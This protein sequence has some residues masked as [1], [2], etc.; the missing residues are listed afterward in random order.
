MKKVS[1]FTIAATFA[2][3]FLGAGYVS[4]QEMKQFFGDYGQNWIWGLLVSV[5]FQTLLGVVILLVSRKTGAVSM[6]R[7]VVSKNIPWLRNLMG[8]LI[9]LM[10]FAIN[11]TM[12]AA[13]GAMLEQLTSGVIPAIW[14]S[15]ALSA[16]IALLALLGLRGMVAVFSLFVPVLR[17]SFGSPL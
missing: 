4:G 9:T 13:F 2:G 12:F 14:G 3:C 16:L 1:F 10:L 7:V 11:V 17:I 6:D 15:L 5:V 8:I